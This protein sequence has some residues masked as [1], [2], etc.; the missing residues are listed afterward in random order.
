MKHLCSQSKDD[1]DRTIWLALVNSRGLAA[2][3]A[4]DGEPSLHTS[5][6]LT[7]LMMAFTGAD[8]VGFP[9]LLCH[10]TVWWGMHWQLQHRRPAVDG[11]VVGWLVNVEIRPMKS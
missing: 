5:I 3:L 6:F 4:F 9:W 7:S 1:S 8:Q 2:H 11:S 10:G